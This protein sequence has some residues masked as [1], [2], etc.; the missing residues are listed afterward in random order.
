M[1]YSVGTRCGNKEAQRKLD[2]QS[3]EHPQNIEQ[4]IMSEA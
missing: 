4:N 3:I 2:V 1:K